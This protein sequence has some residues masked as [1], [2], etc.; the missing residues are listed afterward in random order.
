[1][2]VYSSSV[3]SCHIEITTKTLV[4]T[5]PCQ[6]VSDDTVHERIVL[7]TYFYLDD[8]NTRSACWIPPVPTYS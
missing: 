8:T 7:M 5:L 1:M 4:R 2:C 3:S 6:P